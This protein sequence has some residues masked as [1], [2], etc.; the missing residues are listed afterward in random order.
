MSILFGVFDMPK[1]V[2]DVI[3]RND[4]TRDS[5]ALFKPPR[6]VKISVERL[7]AGI[8]SGLCKVRKIGSCKAQHLRMRI[9]RLV[10]FKSECPQSRHCLV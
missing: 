1:N 2:I 10:L 6:Q 9:D 3:L 5:L 4:S 8:L 7:I